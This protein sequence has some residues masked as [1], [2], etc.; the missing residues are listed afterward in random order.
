MKILST[1]AFIA[2]YTN[3]G[4]N[5]AA[6]LERSDES[7]KM[8]MADAAMDF[9]EAATLEGVD[10]SEKMMADADTYEKEGLMADEAYGC[11]W[12]GKWK[13]MQ[14]YAWCMKRKSPY[15][16]RCKRESKYCFPMKRVNRS[17][18][19]TYYCK[20]RGCGQT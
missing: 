10:E 20:P 19:T 8:M 14:A 5:E 12:G 1:L 15:P 17:R 16:S 18:G 9:N 13:Y 3:A 11:C 7:E 4:S 2:L 6:T